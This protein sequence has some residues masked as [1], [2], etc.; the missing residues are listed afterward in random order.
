MNWRSVCRAARIRGC[1]ELAWLPAASRRE[2]RK[3]QANGFIV[4]FAQITARVRL[5]LDVEVIHSGPSEDG[6]MIPGVRDRAP[7]TCSRNAGQSQHG[8]QNQADGG[9]GASHVCGVCLRAGRAREL[10]C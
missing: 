7:L 3:Y 6:N 8:E 2:G 1:A 10:G 4:L 5:R 9:G